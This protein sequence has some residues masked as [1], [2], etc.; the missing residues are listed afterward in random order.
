MLPK[1]LVTATFFSLV[2]GDSIAV[3]LVR[4]KADVVYVDTCRV[5]TQMAVFVVRQAWVGRIHIVTSE[6]RVVKD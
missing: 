1:L 5:A 2:A 3:E 6:A 4:L